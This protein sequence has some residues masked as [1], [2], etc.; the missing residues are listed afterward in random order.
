M[1]SILIVCVIFYLAY[2]YYYYYYGFKIII[3]SKK[4]LF[5][6]RTC[7]TFCC[8]SIPQ[9]HLERTAKGSGNT[10]FIAYSK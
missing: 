6:M 4:Y 5:K 3:Y 2:Y 9:K 7:I 1:P 10:D 8:K